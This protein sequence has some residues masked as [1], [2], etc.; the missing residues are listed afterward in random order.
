MLEKITLKKGITIRGTFI[1]KLILCKTKNTAKLI[2][3]TLLQ[4]YVKYAKNI[5]DL[6]CSIK[7]NL[8]LCSRI[9]ILK[10]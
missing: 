5:F 10:L 1:S 9:K 2:S 8:Y 7:I 6:F 3:K 4:R